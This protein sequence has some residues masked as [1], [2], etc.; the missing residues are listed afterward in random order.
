[1]QCNIF[2]VSTTLSFKIFLLYIFLDKEI[3]KKGF[4]LQ[5]ARGYFLFHPAG[6]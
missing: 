6:G 1:M 4:Y 5:V 3:T 2:I